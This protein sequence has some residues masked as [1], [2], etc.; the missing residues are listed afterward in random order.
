MKRH[1][2]ESAYSLFAALTCAAVVATLRSAGGDHSELPS[3][4]EMWQMIQAQQ[5]QI[6]ALSALVRVEPSRRPPRRAP[7]SRLRK[8]AAASAKADRLV[9]ALAGLK[10]TQQQ[11]EA[12]S[13][14]RSKNSATAAFGAA[15]L[16]GYQHLGGRLRRTACQ[17]P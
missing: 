14:W 9:T 7:N 13:R 15:G 2:N 4:A 11:V 5:Q 16:V 1:Y 6:E 17:L 3:Q 8:T 12:T 10:A